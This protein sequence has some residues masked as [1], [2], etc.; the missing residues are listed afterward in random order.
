M[1]Q[2][3][4]SRSAAFSRATSLAKRLQ[5]AAEALQPVLVSDVFAE[6]CSITPASIDTD[7][8]FSF[9]DGL[10]QPMPR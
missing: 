7:Q 2:L 8:P 5:T 4:S 1:N 6:P 3:T 10:P 9:A